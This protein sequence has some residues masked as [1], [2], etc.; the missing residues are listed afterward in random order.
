MD[1]TSFERR[2][3]RSKVVSLSCYT[4]LSLARS[5]WGRFLDHPAQPSG[6][7]FGSFIRPVIGFG[8]DLTGSIYTA[9]DVYFYLRFRDRS[10]LS[11]R[12]SA[13]NV[14]GGYSTHSI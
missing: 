12:G 13:H 4:I 10:Q 14:F 6:H 5:V 1:I 3:V 8:F 11:E 7:C 2:K 9:M